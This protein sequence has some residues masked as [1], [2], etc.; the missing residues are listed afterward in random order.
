MS[1]TQHTP[2]PW[3]VIDNGNG[4]L[5][6]GA[7]EPDGTPCQPARVN[8]NAQEEPWATVTKANARLI[9]AAP[10][11]LEACRDLVQAYDVG[12]GKSAVGVR[13][14]IARAAI[15]LAEQS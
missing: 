1:E 2:G 13:I 15:A 7:K 9:A 4:T 14:D 3:H 10:A 5:S 6:I 12:M 8:G 11:L